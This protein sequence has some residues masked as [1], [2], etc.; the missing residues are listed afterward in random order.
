LAQYLNGWRSEC[1]PE[2]R[3]FLSR[4]AGVFGVKL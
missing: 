1:P 2:L 4:L 3:P